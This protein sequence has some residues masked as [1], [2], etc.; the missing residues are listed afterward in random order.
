MG[1]LKLVAIEAVA[2]MVAAGCGAPPQ[3]APA[4]TGSGTLVPILEVTDGDTLHVRY[5]G[6]DERV[7]LIGVDTPEVPWYGGAG[8]CFGVEAGVYARRR[9]DGKT[10]RLVFD[11]NRRDRYGRLLA[12]VY[13]GDEL[14]NMTLVREGYATA[15]P[16]P[17]D[18]RMAAAFGHAEGVA[19]A[20]GK[21]LWSACDSM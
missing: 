21:G 8:Q 2:V 12:Y 13:V 4:P 17:P 9:L 15:D 11:V 10:V 20:A 16:V 5:Q 6:E 18:T 7:R 3:R 19:R 14:F 1:H